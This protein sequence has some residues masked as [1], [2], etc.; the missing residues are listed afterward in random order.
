MA[1]QLA[2]DQ[3]RPADEIAHSDHDHHTATRR[4]V[5]IPFA[6]QN[7]ESQLPLPARTTNLLA[8]LKREEKKRPKQKAQGAGHVLAAMTR[9]RSADARAVL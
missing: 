2:F 3:S 4:I 7:P 5:A 1:V 9:G 8:I 6:V